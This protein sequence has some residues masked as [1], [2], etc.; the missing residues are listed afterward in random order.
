MGGRSVN[1]L[2]SQ[3][4]EA[5]RVRNVEAKV[6]GVVLTVCLLSSP[7]PFCQLHYCRTG[8][9]SEETMRLFSLLLV[10]GFRRFT[11]L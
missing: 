9:S 1:L 7:G 6:Q 11:L 10:I 8:A 3:R 2:T 4:D 5:E